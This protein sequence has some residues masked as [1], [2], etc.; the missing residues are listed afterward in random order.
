MVVRRNVSRTH[1]AASFEIYDYPGD[2]YKTTDGEQYALSRL[3]EL[4]SGFEITQGFG[5]VRGLETGG[6]FNLTGFPR[7]DQNREYL[8]VNTSYQLTGDAYEN[9]AG[10]P[11]QQVRCTV[12]AIHSGQTYRSPRRTPKPEIMG[13]QSAVV[14]G[15]AGN[16]IWTDEFGRV[17]VKFHWDRYSKADDTSS[18]WI[19]VIQS[20][21][22][23]KWGSVWLPRIG[24]EVLVEF[25][26]GDPDQP[27]ITGRVY[28]GDN[29][30]PYE[31]PANKTM[32]GVKTNSSLGGGGFNEIRFE[33][34]KDEEQI[35]IHAQKNQDIRIEND[36]FE[37][38]GHDSHLIV[39][40]DKLEHVEANRSEKIDLDH[41]EEIG[42]DRHLKIIGKQNTDIGESLS[43]VV[44]GDVSEKFNKNH[45]EVVADDL[46]I[47]ATNICI[48]ATTNIT[49]K[50]GD[51]FIAIEASGIKIGTKGDI[52]IDAG[53]NLTEESGMNTKIKAGINV[54]LEAGAS[55]TVK[56]GAMVTV[57]G[58]LVKIN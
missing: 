6:L 17:K 34:K 56:G 22:G 19:R 29:M 33:D 58:P 2:Y 42:K 46:Y 45:S 36:H 21:A 55:N 44:A 51:S 54:D 57:Q 5:D 37:Y 15:K 1:D 31:L 8:I 27:I 47:K 50:V 49:I 40:N 48:E 41:T 18:C 7:D 43:I 38:I 11:S 13:P 20:L 24:Q 30:P 53:M 25:L 28:N 35:F 10:G 39:K 12:E 14:V 9:T 26:E 23:Q 52:V 16:E 32:S 4:S 3:E